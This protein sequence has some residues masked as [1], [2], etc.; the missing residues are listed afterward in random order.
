MTPLP[1]EGQRSPAYKV[2][3]HV[4]KMLAGFHVDVH[5]RGSKTGLS[6]SVLVIPDVQVACLTS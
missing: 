2:A 5:G 1:P 4:F 3:V 6:L